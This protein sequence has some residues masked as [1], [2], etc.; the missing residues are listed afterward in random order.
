MGESSEAFN[1]NE[2]HARTRER[3]QVAELTNTVDQKRST[4]FLNKKDQWIDSQVSDVPYL[5]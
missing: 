4:G 5:Q 2:C 3:L 1:R